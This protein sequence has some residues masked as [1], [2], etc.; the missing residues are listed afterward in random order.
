MGE[1]LSSRVRIRLPK[2][3][4]DSFHPGPTILMGKLGEFVVPIGALELIKR[5]L[6]ESGE[7]R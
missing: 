5:K 6:A 1:L 2:Y 7:V 3:L 4:M